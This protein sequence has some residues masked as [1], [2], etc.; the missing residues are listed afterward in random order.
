MKNSEITSPPEQ[1]DVQFPSAI[2]PK[3]LALRKKDK[4]EKYI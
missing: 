1:E 3:L 2:K 4:K